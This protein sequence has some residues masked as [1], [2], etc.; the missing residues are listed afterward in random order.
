MSLGFDVGA[1][2]KLI[3]TWRARA[4][5]AY[6]HKTS[7]DFPSPGGRQAQ[8]AYNDSLRDLLAPTFTAHPIVRLAIPGRSLDGIVDRL[9][10]ALQPTSTSPD[11]GVSTSPPES[12]TLAK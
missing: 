5:R 12:P 3:S 10:Q 8:R 7:A 1:Y 11:A 9:A 2:R 6:A 4:D